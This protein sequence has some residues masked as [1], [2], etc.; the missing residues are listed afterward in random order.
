[1]TRMLVGGYRRPERPSP[2][3]QPTGR[4][5]AR[6]R[7]GGTLPDRAVGRRLARARA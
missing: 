6:L 3:M 2:G 7:S 4:R 1:M 5:G